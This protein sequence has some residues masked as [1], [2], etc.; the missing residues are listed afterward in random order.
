MTMAS[1]PI[2]WN[3]FAPTAATSTA[4]T[5]Q[6]SFSAGAR[7]ATKV[8]KGFPFDQGDRMSWTE[9]LKKLG[10]RRRIAAP[11]PIRPQLPQWKAAP[12]QENWETGKLKSCGTRRVS[13]FPEFQFSGGGAWRFCI[14]WKDES[15]WPVEAAMPGTQ[16]RETGASWLCMVMMRRAE[17]RS[18]AIRYMRR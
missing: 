17:A 15:E 4:P 10:Q 3:V 13:S 6:T 11:A 2:G 1:G 18:P 8:P 9:F 14:A 5:E 16:H 12:G 7:D